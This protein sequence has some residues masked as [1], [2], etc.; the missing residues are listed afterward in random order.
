M[1]IAEDIKQKSFKDSWTKARINLI[2][3][4]NW[5]RDQYTTIFKKYGILQQHYNVLRIVNGKSPKP[6]FPSHIL[7][8]MLDK[9]R[10]LTRLV[11]KLVK[12]GLLRRQVCA[13]NR[14]MVEIYI[15]DAGKALLE[16][17]TQDMTSVDNTLANLSQEEAEQLSQLLDKWRG[18]K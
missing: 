14:R 16:D 5:M 13:T 11:D 12:K 10:D 2:Y 6:A 8:V 17:M 18:S 9:K 7:D 3:T 4:S 15:T 1:S